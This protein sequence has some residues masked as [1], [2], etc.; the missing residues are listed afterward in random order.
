[1]RIRMIKV[2]ERG[3]V[4]VRSNSIRDLVDVEDAL[5]ELGFVRVKFISF[6][7]HVLNWKCKIKEDFYGHDATAE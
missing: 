6:W 2:G 1:M 7:K 5:L 4:M 3:R